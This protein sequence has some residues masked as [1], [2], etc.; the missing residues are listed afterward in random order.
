MARHWSSDPGAVV[1]GFEGEGCIGVTG[2]VTATGAG[3]G[4]GGAAAVEDPLR[5]TNTAAIIARITATPPIAA[6][7][8]AGLP[9]R[10]AFGIATAGAAAPGLGVAGELVCAGSG[11]EISCKQTGQAMRLPMYAVS[12]R[13]CW[14]HFGQTAMNSLI[15]YR[16]NGLRPDLSH[17]RRPL[18]RR[19]FVLVPKVGRS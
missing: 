18:H 6:I 1:A 19:Y 5:N 15:I 17:I 2:A 7:R 13:I 14:R 11:I 3:G 8:I 4:G 9:L 12:H 16:G 10:S